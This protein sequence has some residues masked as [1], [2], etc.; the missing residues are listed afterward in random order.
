MLFKCIKRPVKKYRGSLAPVY[1]FIEA[2]TAST[3]K[4]LADKLEHMKSGVGEY[5]A[6][7]AEKYVAPVHGDYGY[8]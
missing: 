4:K 7:V 5:S 1:V 8:L 6:V 2:E 3:A